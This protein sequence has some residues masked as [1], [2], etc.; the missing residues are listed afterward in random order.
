M[1]NRSVTP[2]PPA[3]FTPEMC[4]Y[5][6]LQPFRYWC[7]KVLPLVYDDSL[8]YY[9]LLCKVVDY[10]NKTMEDV[11]TLHDDVTNLHTAYEQLQNY[12]NVYFSSLDVQE[13]INNKLNEMASNGELTSLISPLLPSLISEWLSKNITPTSPVIDKTLSISGA[14]A[15]AKVTGERLLKDGISY[16][17]QYSTLIN[18]RG[19]FDNTKYN[20]NGSSF[21]DN[22]HYKEATLGSSVNLV[23]FSAQLFEPIKNTNADSLDVYCLVDLRNQTAVGTLSLWLSDTIMNWTNEHVAYSG[24]I[25][26]EFGAINIYKFTLEKGGSSN[27]ITNVILRVDNINSVPEQFNFKFALLTDSTLYDLFKKNK[28]NIDKTLSISGAGADAKVTGEKLLK[29]GISYSYQYSTLINYRGT[30]DNTKYNLNGSSFLD[31]SHYKEATLG[32]SV[33]LV[34]FSAQLFE[35]IKNTNADSLDVYCLVDL[36]NQTAVGTLSLWLSDTIMNWTNEHVA[37][38]GTISVEFG[39]I[40]IYKFTLEKGG[41]SNDITNVILRVDNINS[42][43]EQF[44][45]KFA[46][47]TDS[48]LYDL[49]SIKRNIEDYDTEICFWGDSLT[50]GTGG[51]GTTYP[52]ICANEL[53]ITNYKN[54]GVG[55]ETANTISCRQGGNSLI[56]PV[57]KVNRYEL[58]QMKD[59]Y[60]KK[61]NPLR[62][63]SGSNTVNPIFINGVKCNLELHQSSVTDENAYYTISGYPN[64]LKAE[65]PVKFS[66]CDIYAKINVIFVG[67]NGPDLQERLNIIDSMISKCEKRYIVMGLSTGSKSNRETEEKTMVDKY[68]VHYFNTRHLVSQYGCDI[69]GITPTTSDMVDIQNGIIPSSLRSDSVHLNANGYTALGKLLAQKIRA[70]GYI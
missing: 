48:T 61:C 4:N 68:G 6:T 19:T 33:N 37:Y 59:I 17:Y 25:S 42:V 66:G 16:S 3:D 30:F 8:S 35:P 23:G 39:A 70:N 18:Y 44:N 9:E 67:Q 53:S 28:I 45:F 7:Q 26:V 41:S 69:V 27:D 11:E 43:P 56:L 36:R 32:S 60:G 1:N 21:L 24:T 10:L 13:E 34:G 22:S 65:T 31:N 62:Q 38:S 29:D 40:N 14:G 51:G 58:A 47:L 20:L 15:D 63:G 57:G 55:G 50:A 52:L 49:L 2:L 54:C 46:L 12:V 64:E 5:R